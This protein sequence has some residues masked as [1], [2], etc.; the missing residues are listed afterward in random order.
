MGGFIQEKLF[1]LSIMALPFL[2]A[3]TMREAAKAYVAH[4]LG[5]TSQRASGRLSL[6]PLSHVDPAGTIVIPLIIFFLGVPFL[7]GH[8]KL[9]HIQ[10]H[11]FKNMKRDNILAALA[12]VFG[13]LV[14]AIFCAYVFRIA[15]Y[16]GATG[17]DW[18][19]NAMY[20]GV[21]LNCVFI[22]FS[23]L[24]IPPTDGSKVVE[25]FLPYDMLQSYR[26]IAPFGFFIIIGIIMF[27]REII[28]V[29][30]EFLSN[31]ILVLANVP[32]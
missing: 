23:L 27:A 31:L 6:N 10:T 8:G 20:F 1:Q 28:T 2:L 3:V 26:S 15:V 30:S 12:G 21:L 16:F 24:P 22:I 9:V 5:D 32:I 19:L 13:N 29:P 25:Q 17:Q 14:M 18:I 7:I 11:G 4:W